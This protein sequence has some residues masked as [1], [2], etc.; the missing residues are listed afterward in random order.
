M[1]RGIV[2]ISEVV[3]R[4]FLDFESDTIKKQAFINLTN[5]SNKN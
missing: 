3:D 2:R 5:N 1:I 4:F